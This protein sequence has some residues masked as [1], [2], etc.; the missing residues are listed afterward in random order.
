MRRMA[1]K[2]DGDGV[3]ELTTALQTG[4]KDSPAILVKVKT[5]VRSMAGVGMTSLVKQKCNSC[6]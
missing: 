1:K 3:M 5:V 2:E 4:Q 6:A